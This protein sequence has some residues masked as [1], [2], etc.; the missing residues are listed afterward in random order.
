MFWMVY[1]IVLTK[2]LYQ[3]MIM[4]ETTTMLANLAT[5]LSM[6]AELFLFDTWTPVMIKVTE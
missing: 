4:F 2:K 3:M 1:L 6:T 5:K